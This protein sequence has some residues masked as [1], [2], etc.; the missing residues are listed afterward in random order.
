MSFAMQ[1]QHNR[2]RIETVEPDQKLEI[3]VFPNA[4]VILDK[5]GD[6]AWVSKDDLPKL[7]GKLA[8]IAGQ[9][10]SSKAA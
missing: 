2:H 8:E 3:C 9:H 10:I 6:T 4:V 1:L 5:D 7:I